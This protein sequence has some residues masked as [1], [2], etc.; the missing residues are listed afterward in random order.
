[1]A[2]P[3]SDAPHGHGELVQVHVTATDEVPLD[4]G[5][6]VGGGVV[7]GGVVGGGVGGETVGNVTW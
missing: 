7:G 5:G 1:M 3:E 6:V 2:M 4:G